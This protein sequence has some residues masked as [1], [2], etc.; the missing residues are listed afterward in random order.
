MEKIARTYIYSAKFQPRGIQA[1]MY[2]SAIG[3]V[4]TCTSINGLSE[5][6]TKFVFK[7]N[8]SCCFRK[9]LLDILYSI[10]KSQINCSDRPFS[11]KDSSHR[12]LCHERYTDRPL[13]HMR[14]EGKKEPSISMIDYI[15][16]S[17]HN[18]DRRHVKG[19]VHGYGV[20]LLIN[21]QN[22]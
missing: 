9:D 12:G 16:S 7:V 3:S 18:S 5:K 6:N 22:I 8:S 4:C 1:I 15:D 13:V 19:N 11:C 2:K 14:W 10:C 20:N 17:R 21:N